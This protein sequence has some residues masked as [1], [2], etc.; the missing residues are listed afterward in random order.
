MGKC[1]LSDVKDHFCEKVKACPGNAGDKKYAAE[2]EFA[3]I[4]NVTA[5]MDSRVIVVRRVR[6]QHR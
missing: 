1:L 4:E 5:A 2:T 3:S 6:S